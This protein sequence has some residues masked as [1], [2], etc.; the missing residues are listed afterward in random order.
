[1]SGRI[2]ILI[3]DDEPI[4]RTSLEHW[5]RDEGCVVET[6]SSGKEALSKLAES[7]WDLFLL[8]IRMPGMD[9]LEL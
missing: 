2:R 1:V 8:D 6:A 5:F 4:V 3:V 7:E 9:G